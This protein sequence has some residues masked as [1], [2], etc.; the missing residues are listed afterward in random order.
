MKIIERL[1]SLFKPAPIEKIEVIL[2]VD[3]EGWEKAFTL[4]KEKGLKGFYVEVKGSDTNPD[5]KLTFVSTKQRL[6]NSLTLNFEDLPTY[7]PKRQ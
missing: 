3:Y 1:L 5:V 6:N 7:D 4:A 2:D